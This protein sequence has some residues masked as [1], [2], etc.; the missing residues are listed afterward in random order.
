MTRSANRRSPEQPSNRNPSIRDQPTESGDDGEAPSAAPG[1]SSASNDNDDGADRA[2]TAGA[3]IP[4]AS[5]DEGRSTPT[6]K[7][8]IVTHDRRRRSTFRSSGGGEK[9]RSVPPTLAQETRKAV[10]LNR[11]VVMAVGG[12][13]VVAIVIGLAQ[14]LTQ[15]RGSGAKTPTEADDEPVYQP[16]GHAVLPKFDYT[17]LPQQTAL[18]V[19]TEPPKAP[20]PEARSSP[21]VVTETR[22]ATAPV[23][24]RNAEE[25]EAA[26]QSPLFPGGV[27]TAA[28]VLS[29]GSSSTDATQA[30]LERLR[31]SL[32]T[33][34]DLTPRDQGQLLAGDQ[35]EAFLRQ[36]VDE[37]I[38]LKNGLQKPLS[39]Y[40][41][42][43]G[44]VIPAALI[45]GLNSD[46]PGE[47]IG[48]VTEHV[49]DTAIG[50]HLLIPQGAKIL[51]R[52]NAQ[53][54]FGRDR[55]QIVWDRLIM[56]NGDSA[57][58]EAMVGTDKAGYAGLAD[59]V[60][61]H[62]G[63]L[64][65]AVVLS[66]FISVGAN[67]ATDRGDNVTD[68]L[69]DAAAQQAAEIGSEIV[70]RQLDLQPTITVRPGFKL[71]ILVNKDIVFP[72]PYSGG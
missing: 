55:A 67:L 36:P 50:R 38:Y 34:Q 21:P 24:D 23:R 7:A 12:G 11:K 37:S 62:F 14:G 69:G 32:P 6:S 70:N 64:I 8:T 19:V 56:P 22:A 61:H 30:A 52:Y 49:Y 68:A 72:E 16:L 40:E 35:Q 47:I 29:A 27:R 53:I 57:Q 66:S 10:R 18:T 41:I 42:K 4:T 1:P 46:L 5:D 59:Q 39:D 2:P 9:P 25:E 13:L 54:G 20:E 44:T 60:D 45:T 71:N 51:G 65:G 48:Q 58:L 28:S 17:N 63:R 33:L 26:L 15:V 3:G 31:G 43:A